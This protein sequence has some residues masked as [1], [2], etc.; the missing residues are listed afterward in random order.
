[1]VGHQ[2]VYFKVFQG[3]DMENPL[4]YALEDIFWSTSEA[5]YAVYVPV[6]WKGSIRRNSLHY[7][8]YAQMY[9]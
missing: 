5:Y 8:E 3:V 6:E 2:N 1:M 7:L 4:V 9:T